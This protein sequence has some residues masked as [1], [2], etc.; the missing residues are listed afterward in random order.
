M[1]RG[2]T[3]KSVFFSLHWGEWVAHYAKVDDWVVPPH[4]F[5]LNFHNITEMGKVGKDYS[6]SPGPASLLKQS[7]PGAHGTGLQ[8]D[9]SWKVPVK[10]SLQLLWA[11][12]C[13]AWSLVTDGPDFFPLL[14]LVQNPGQWQQSKVY[15]DDHGPEGSI[16]NYPK[17]IWMS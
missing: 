7:H 16:I 12:C 2:I 11:T 14:F 1:I 6:G 17:Q 5:F 8:P 13:S 3:L 9:S 10:E 15:G 4:V